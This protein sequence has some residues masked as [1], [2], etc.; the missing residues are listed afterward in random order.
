MNSSCKYKF[1]LYKKQSYLLENN[2]QLFTL[3]VHKKRTNYIVIE[4]LKILTDVYTYWGEMI[5][6]RTQ[7]YKKQAAIN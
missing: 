5:F 4:L 2:L 1:C 3:L 6:Y 7:F